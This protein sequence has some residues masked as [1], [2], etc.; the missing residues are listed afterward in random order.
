MYFHFLTNNKEEVH[1]FRTHVACATGFLRLLLERTKITEEI[2]WIGRDCFK[3]PKERKNHLK[4]ARCSKDV[5][6]HYV[7][8]HGLDFDLC[9]KLG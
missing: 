3:L 2:P 8:A 5:M 7:N 9:S 4:I 6:K 1:T